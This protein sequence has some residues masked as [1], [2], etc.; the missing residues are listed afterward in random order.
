MVQSV[1]SSDVNYPEIKKLD[2]EDRSY[3]ASIYEIDINDVNVMIALGQPKYTYLD[4]GI[5]YFPIYLV[6]GNTFDKQIGVFESLSSR[7]PQ[8]TD[9]DGE[10]DI[11]EMGEPLVYSFV[12]KN[13]KILLDAAITKS[14]DTS[15]SEDED[16]ESIADEKIDEVEV[17]VIE[18]K[19]EPEDEEFKPIEIS[20]AFRK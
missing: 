2:P 18:D 6:K 14:E 20:K 11:A 13:P 3:S 15:D 12:D 4:S 1:L 9:E 16:E 5:I 17:E 19:E 10:V 7:I 8:I